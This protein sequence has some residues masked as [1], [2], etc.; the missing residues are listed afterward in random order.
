M[1]I[2]GLPVACGKRPLL[3]CEMSANHNGSL[4]RA[5]E[6]IVTAKAVGADLCKIQV[7][8]PAKLANARGGADK[9]L[10]SGPWAGRTLGSLYAEGAIDLAWLPHLFDKAADVGIPL[11]A[12]VFDLDAIDL[13]EGFGCPAYKVSSFELRDAPLIRKAALTGKPLILSTGMATPH[14][15]SAALQAASGTDYALLH[16]VS[17]YPCPVEKANLWRISHMRRVY[18]C[19]IGWSDHTMGDVAALTATALGAAI[20][21]KHLTLSRKDGGLDA[22]FSMEPDD[23]EDMAK[24]VKVAWAAYQET[25]APTPYKDLRATAA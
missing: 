19:P 4:A 7:Y 13:L 6:I 25:D 15:I 23:F 12:S 1:N 10:Q 22:A 16:C 9:V 3:V 20:I 2:A 18:G 21:E 14:D 5:L 24:R 11:F 8:D 17:A